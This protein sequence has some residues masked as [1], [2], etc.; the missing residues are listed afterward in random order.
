S[1]KIHARNRGHSPHVGRLAAPENR[2]VD[3]TVV[4]A[5][6]DAPDNGGDAS[7][8]VVEFGPFLRWDPDRAIARLLRRRDFVFADEAVDASLDA[9]RD[10]IGLVEALHE[11]V[12]QPELIPA[13]V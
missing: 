1:E 9:F 8:T 2:Q 6:T 5:K 13:H 10:L 3:P 4:G 12:V 7:R 11:I